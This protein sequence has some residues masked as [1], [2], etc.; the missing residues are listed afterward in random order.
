[1]LLRITTKS[2]NTFLKNSTDYVSL[3]LLKDK[4]IYIVPVLDDKKRIARLIDLNEVKALLPVD[5][6]IM[7]GGKGERMLPLTRHTPKPLLH[8]GKKPIIQYAVDRLEKFGVER[9]HISLRHFGDQIEEY[10]KKKSPAL[11]VVF[12]KEK[13]PLGTAGALGLV[14]KFNYDYVLLTNSDILTNV[15]YEEFY[16][17]AVETK[18]DVAVAS[19]PYSISVPYAIFEL[20]KEEEILNL[21]E[22][23]TYT[24]YANAG[25]YL[26]KTELLKHLPKNQRIDITDLF[27][28]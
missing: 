10:F 23:P 28:H 8:V 26:I 11:E 2:S 9:I 14:K 3:K 17:K 15:D 13:D 1:V 27:L 12:V 7:A 16:L 18:A 20:K 21:V 25:I 4:G 19:I 6:M 22:K 5:V 24:Y